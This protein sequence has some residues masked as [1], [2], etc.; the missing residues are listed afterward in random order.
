[1]LDAKIPSTGDAT[2]WRN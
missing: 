2:E 1:E